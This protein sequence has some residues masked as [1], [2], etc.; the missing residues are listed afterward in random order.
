MARL[1]VITTIFVAANALNNLGSPLLKPERSTSES[2][3]KS[4]SSLP[5]VKD[6]LPSG[7]FSAMKSTVA[8]LSKRLADEQQQSVSD[9]RK[10]KAEYELRLKV[11]TANTSR[12][13]KDNLQ[14]ASR[15][16]EVDKSNNVLRR[17]ASTLVKANEVLKMEL[18]ALSSNLSLAQEFVQEGLAA[19]KTNGSEVQILAELTELDEVALANS[20]K[21][22]LLSDTSGPSRKLSLLVTIGDMHER[23]ANDMVESLASSFSQLSDEPNTSK[24]MLRE[25]FEKK[26]SEVMTRH[27]ASLRHQA[28]LNET[29]IDKE[30]LHERLSE[31]VDH[32]S[33]IHDHLLA[34]VKAAKAFALRLGSPQP[35]AA[36]AGKVIHT[37]DTREVDRGTPKIRSRAARTV[38][39][40]RSRPGRASRTNTTHSNHTK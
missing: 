24:T 36:A 2:A 1:H 10:L 3:G 40:N 12:V 4:K 31:A 23:S 26:L 8:A 25:A 30:K 11:N 5:N 33:K 9:L 17:R 6:F 27:E 37:Q 29:R 38:R 20:K 21:A 14:I 19:S 16:E 22:M 15:V 28:L 13:E 39:R 18:D 32:L 35:S 34:R 7:S